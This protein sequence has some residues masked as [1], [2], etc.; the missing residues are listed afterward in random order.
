MLLP[1]LKYRPERLPENHLCKDAIHVKEDSIHI[2]WPMV[3]WYAALDM[4][5]INLMKDFVRMY[6]HSV[7]RKKCLFDMQCKTLEY[8]KHPISMDSSRAQTSHV[9]TFIEAV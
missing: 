8:I 4:D 3:I 5:A 2:F 6:G 1:K 7:D 9:C